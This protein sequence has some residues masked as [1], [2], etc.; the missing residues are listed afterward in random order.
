M[1]IRILLYRGRY[2]LT[3][4]SVSLKRS[5]INNSLLDLTDNHNLL[6]Y[7]GYTNHHDKPVRRGSVGSLGIHKT[8]FKI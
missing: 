7:P 1:F 4:S 2:G 3:E 8:R 5:A 6:A